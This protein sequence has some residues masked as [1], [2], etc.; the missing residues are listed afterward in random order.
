MVGFLS[1]QG[2]TAGETNREKEGYGPIFLEIE[3]LIGG[4]ACIDLRTKKR[5]SR[6]G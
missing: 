1:P 2:K 5:V 3:N 4:Q 6:I